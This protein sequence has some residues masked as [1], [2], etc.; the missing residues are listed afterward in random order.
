MFRIQTFNKISKDGLKLFDKAKYDVGEVVTDPDGIVVRSAN[1]HSLESG[2]RLMVIGRAGAGTNNIPVNDCTRR[3][4]VVFNA[5]GANANAVKELV[6]S[7]ML[8]AAR[9][10]IAGI[11]HTKG[12]FGQGDRV[13]EL[14]EK[15]KAKFA[16]YEIRGKRLGG[17][18]KRLEGNRSGFARHPGGW[19]CPCWRECN[20]DAIARG[21]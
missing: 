19:W 2:S 6:L 21:E 18:S 1:L 20:P 16:G 11:E 17:P 7:G 4:I 15:D 5:P 3:G 14:V 8:L 13:S 9:N 12:L 10:L